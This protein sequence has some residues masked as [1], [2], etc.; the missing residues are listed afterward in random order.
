LE[1]FVLENKAI[2]EKMSRGQFSGHVSHEFRAM[3]EKAARDKGHMNY[4][5]WNCSCKS[6]EQAAKAILR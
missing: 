3:F 6:V 5:N 1:T 2:I 4:V